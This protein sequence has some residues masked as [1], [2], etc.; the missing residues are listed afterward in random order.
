MNH[1]YKPPSLLP[2][3]GLERTYALIIAGVPLLLILLTGAL[4]QPAPDGGGSTGTAVD[5]QGGYSYQPASPP[6][7]TDP[8]TPDIS[9]AYG[10]TPD[11]PTSGT[12][13]ATGPSPDPVDTQ[14]TQSPA[15]TTG[16]SDPAT[17]VTD[18]FAAI[19]DG[20]FRTAWNLGG[21][22]L[23]SSYSSFVSGFAHTERDDATVDP[24][25]GTTVSVTL[26]ATRDDGTQKSYS[27]RYTV[28]DGVIT[29]ASMTP[30]G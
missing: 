30:T 27:G 8:A 4:P 12:D 29:G 17:T 13:A 23:G 20:D 11:A 28:V 1:T 7:A 19:N 15:G 25:D 10:A 2:S 6:S 21:K 5:G 18:Y 9:T 22:N 26:V 3:A 14:A 24:V 16:A